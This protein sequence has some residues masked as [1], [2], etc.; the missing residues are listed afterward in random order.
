[1]NL[2]DFINTINNDKEITTEVL[3]FILSNIGNNDPQIRDELIYGTCCQLFDEKKLTLSQ[4][5]YLLQKL[6]KDKYLYDNQPSEEDNEV[7]KKINNSVLKRSF[8]ALLLALLLE[9]SRRNPWITSHHISSIMDDTFSWL[10]NEN[11]FRGYDEKLGWIHAFAHGADLL[12]EITK[13][14]PCKDLQV[15]II[16]DI[17]KRIIINDKILLWGE[18]DRLNLVIIELLKLNKIDT[19][20]FYKWCK[21]VESNLFSWEA[22]K[23]SSTFFQSIYFKMKFENLLDN[24]IETYIKDYLLKQYTNN[25]GIL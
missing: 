23:K 6:L 24:N 2:N 15:S 14:E 21:D 25:Q 16:L 4:K 10:L 12:V 18:E 13:L 22:K 11:D 19:L 7:D 8:T 17:L 5:E 9:D 1:M 20:R 3:D